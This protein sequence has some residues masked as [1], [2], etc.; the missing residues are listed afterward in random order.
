MS[1]R[2]RFAARRRA[3][4][5]V[6]LTERVTGMPPSLLCRN[7]IIAR[8]QAIARGSRGS[9]SFFSSIAAIRASPA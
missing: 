7:G 1:R 4:R 8:A 9:I 2:P 3:A 5:F 6:P